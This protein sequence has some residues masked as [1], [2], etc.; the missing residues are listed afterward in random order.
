MIFG[1]AAIGIAVLGIIVMSWDAICYVLSDKHIYED[2]AA[3]I[4]EEEK[5]NVQ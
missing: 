4:A 2:Y 1:F 3:D 5:E